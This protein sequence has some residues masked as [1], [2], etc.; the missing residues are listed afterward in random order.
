MFT[1][2]H[3]DLFVLASGT[4]LRLPEARGRLVVESGRLWL[5][6]GEGDEFLPT[7][8][9][10][11]IDGDAVV[12]SWDRGVIAALRW[13]AAPGPVQR[14]AALARR[15]FARGFFAAAAGFARL[16]R[17]AASIARRTQGCISA[18]ESI[19]SPGALK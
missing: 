2:P 10:I 17:T 13:Q 15:G 1:Q 8:A 4:A 16:A 14:F 12:E 3:P 18:G 6:R 19:A 11:T 5:T 9:S 7:G